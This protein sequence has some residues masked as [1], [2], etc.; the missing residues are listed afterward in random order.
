MARPKSP[1]VKSDLKW[2]D[3]PLM[4]SVFGVCPFRYTSMDPREHQ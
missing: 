3:T 2:P 1:D 4:S